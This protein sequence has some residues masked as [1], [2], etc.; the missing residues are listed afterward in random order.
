MELSIDSFNLLYVLLSFILSVFG[1]YVAISFAIRIPTAESGSLFFWLFLAALALG[2]GGIWSMHFVGMLA[3]NMPM[4]VN[5]DVVLTVVSLVIAVASCMLGLF[6]V[7]RS[8]GEVSR[9]LVAGTATGLGVAGMHYLGM[10]AMIMD[11]AVSYDTTLVVISIVIAVVAA[12]AAL[13]LAFNMRGTMQRLGSA[14]IMGV[15]VC[16]MHYT[17]MFAVKMD[18]MDVGSAAMAMNDGVGGN[19]LATSI[20]VISFA[21]LFLLMMIRRFKK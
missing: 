17:G 14:L 19:T 11:A 4:Q 5:Y 21:L 2:G 8:S 20:F 1:S 7:G 15:A 10:S 3:L 9:L 13:W 6:M 18:A 16:G 12:T